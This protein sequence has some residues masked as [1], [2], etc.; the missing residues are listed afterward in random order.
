VLVRTGRG[1]VT[2]GGTP[3]GGVPC[4]ANK[5]AVGGGFGSPSTAPDHA[6]ELKFQPDI[7]QNSPDGNGWTIGL[8]NLSP[9]SEFDDIAA[10]Y[11]V[12][13]RVS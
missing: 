6:N 2:S 3:L 9:N 10:A 1:P 7:R 8:K 4:A 13:V 12:C 11:A 5:K